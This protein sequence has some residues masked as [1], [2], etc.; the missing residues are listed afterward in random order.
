MVLIIFNYNKIW[1]TKQLK[2]VS[3]YHIIKN[4][5]MIIKEHITLYIL[6]GEEQKIIYLGGEG[7]FYFFK[8][9]KKNLWVTVNVFLLF[10][11]IKYVCLGTLIIPM[12][13][14]IDRSICVVVQC[15]NW[16]YDWHIG[17]KQLSHT[18]FV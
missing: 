17:P 18:V 3:V 13:F 1:V 15:P 12:Q 4:P 6:F 14:P 2:C 16:N 7:F 11:N 10:Y 8:N 9:G 5:N